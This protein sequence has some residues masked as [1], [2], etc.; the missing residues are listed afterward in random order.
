MY[1]SLKDVCLSNKYSYH[2][3]A[4][5]DATLVY[6]NVTATLTRLGLDPKSIS[7]D[8]VLV[9][10]KHA[11]FVRRVNYR[12]ISAEYSSVDI[13]HKRAIEK[14]LNNWDSAE[15]GVH[16]YIAIRAWQEYYSKTGKLPGAQD[17]EVENDIAELAAYAEAYLKSVGYD[18]E[19]GQR[20][21]GLLRELV[22][23]GG[24]E[25]LVVASLAGGIV[26]QEIIKVRFIYVD[27]RILADEFRS[28]LTSTCQ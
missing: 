24:G 14:A 16:E 3:R 6:Q 20:T 8:E 1:R 22:R 17:E 25:L 21:L 23:T 15:S 18:A 13:H 19:L 5:R 10:T 11:N 9:F 4:Q 28:L 26:A 12:P 7:L 27:G 2:A